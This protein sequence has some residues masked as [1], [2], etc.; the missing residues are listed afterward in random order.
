MANDKEF[1]KAAD[2]TDAQRAA[3]RR[4]SSGVMVVKFADI[5]AVYE[6]SPE[7]GAALKLKMEGFMEA[8][9]RDPKDFDA[10]VEFGAPP[11]Q[12]IGKVADGVIAASAQFVTQLKVIQDAQRGVSETLSGLNLQEVVTGIKSMAVNAASAGVTGAKSLFNVMSKIG[13]A[14]TGS[15]KKKSEEQAHVEAMIADLP[16]ANLRMKKA[17]QD[18]KDTA[19][20]LD[21]VI[22]QAK[23][24]G[25]AR[26]D[27]VKELNIYLGAAPEVLKRYDE[28][29]IKEAKDDYDAPGGQNQE[30]GLRLEEII[31]AKEYFTRQYNQ[32]ESSAAQAFVAATQLKQL[33]E[34]MQE[35]KLGIKQFSETRENEWKAL[36]AYAN[37]SGSSLKAAMIMTE[38]GQIGEQVHK[39]AIDM[40]DKSRELT[41][42]Q[43]GLGTISNKTLLETLEHISRD[44]LEDE[45]TR[46]R[47]M[48]EAET[49]R[50]Q[51]R[52]A[53][54]ALQKTI[55]EVKNHRVLDAAPEKKAVVI[56][57]AATNDNVDGDGNNVSGVTPSPAKRADGSPKP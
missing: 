11:I 50:L 10:I 23:T 57:K 52:A 32:L 21:A 18:L 40:G 35:Q 26:I 47:K 2:I 37:L 4:R 1:N 45:K 41:K 27:L 36:M 9:D 31:K 34:T 5:D 29:Y 6:D 38:S 30:N 43:E 54:E 25:R 53:V 13:K 15:D 3:R 17:S 44:L 49:Q 19:K 12:E 42:A 33:I 51:T 55:E 16:K 46:E 20:G 8:I 56:D 22:E 7:E 28:I 48:L 39:L 14:F 24:L